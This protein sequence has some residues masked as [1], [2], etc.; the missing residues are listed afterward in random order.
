MSN[1]II[2]QELLFDG[3]KELLMS[4]GEGLDVGVGVWV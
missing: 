2:I 4:G 1:F 3:V